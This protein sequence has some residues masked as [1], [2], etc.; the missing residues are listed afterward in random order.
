MKIVEHDDSFE[1]SIKLYVAEIIDE[2]GVPDVNK[3]DNID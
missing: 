1:M 3:N 2:N